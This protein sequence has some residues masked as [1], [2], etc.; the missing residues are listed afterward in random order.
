MLG[1]LGW[2]LS[3]GVLGIIAWIMGHSYMRQCRAMGVEPE[4]L[5]RAG[6]ILGMIQTILIILAII[7]VV[8]LVL[9]GGLAGVSA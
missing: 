6:Y 5:A 7:F 4:G 9:T 2:I 8:A 1:L 3:C